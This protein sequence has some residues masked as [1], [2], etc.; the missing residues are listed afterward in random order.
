MSQRFREFKNERVFAGLTGRVLG[1]KAVPCFDHG[2]YPDREGT[3]RWRLTDDLADLHLC[4]DAFIACDDYEELIQALEG[5]FPSQVEGLSRIERVP[6]GWV[7]DSESGKQ[8]R[9]P[10]TDACVHAYPFAD[11][12]IKTNQERL[13]EHALIAALS[14]LAVCGPL[15]LSQEK[16]EGVKGPAFFDSD[17]TIND[18]DFTGDPAPK[19]Y[20]FLKYNPTRARARWTREVNADCK[21][22]RATLLNQQT[23]ALRATILTAADQL[24]YALCGR[25]D[26]LIRVLRR[27]EDAVKDPSSRHH[28]YGQGYG[29]PIDYPNRSDR[30]GRHI[31]GGWDGARVLRAYVLLYDTAFGRGAHRKLGAFQ[32][33]LSEL[34]DVRKIKEIKAQDYGAD[35]SLSAWFDA[36]LKARMP[37]GDAQNGVGEITPKARRV[38]HTA[39]PSV[40]VTTLSSTHSSSQ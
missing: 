35:A 12:W 10:P 28:G 18:T 36:A 20:R 14:E 37:R 11:P 27:P 9:Q 16:V 17:L 38:R 15:I 32:D 26:G 1:A 8:V 22:E 19:G 39:N 24:R 4:D 34:R 21:K 33:V 6:T 40:A 7:Y 31:Y 29:A 5:R 30:Y 3:G 2:G 23:A 25:D 13:T